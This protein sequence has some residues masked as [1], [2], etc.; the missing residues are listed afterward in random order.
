VAAS[1]KSGIEVSEPRP[2]GHAE[3]SEVEEIDDETLETAR[4]EVSRTVHPGVVVRFG[5]VSIQIYRALK[6][7][8]FHFD[9]SQDP[10]IVV[11]ALV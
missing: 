8:S 11:E 10:P 9:E 3:D 4:I 6:S 2:A 7:V 1:F 5:R